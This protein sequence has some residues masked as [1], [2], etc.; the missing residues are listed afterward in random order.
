MAIRFAKSPKACRWLAA[1]VTLGVF[2]VLQMP[3]LG[4]EKH[5]PVSTVRVAGIVLK[6]VR[7]DK[8]A[9]FRRVEPLI[10]EAA[11]NGATIVCTTECFLDGYA[12]ADKSIPLDVYRSLGEKVPDGP[13]FQRLVGKRSTALKIQRGSFIVIYRL[14]G[15]NA[16]ALGR[17]AIQ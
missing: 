16:A 14:G 15:S 4:E 6:W 3:A 12:I 1:A 11:Q 17:H 5:T 2:A 9:N 7:G 8:D 13:Y 10:R